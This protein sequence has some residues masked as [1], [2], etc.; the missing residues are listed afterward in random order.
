MLD[1]KSWRESSH[2]VLIGI[3]KVVEGGSGKDER[4]RDAM[5]V[6]NDLLSEM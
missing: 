5:V 2:L 1:L 4:E 6:T 3:K